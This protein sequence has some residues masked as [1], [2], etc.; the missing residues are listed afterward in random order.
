M[1]T[2]AT[3]KLLARI[4]AIGSG[5]TTIFV[6]SGSVTDPVNVTKLLSMGVVSSMAIGVLLAGRFSGFVRQSKVLWTLIGFFLLSGLASVLLSSSP[7][8]QG[9]YGS[10][11]GVITFDPGL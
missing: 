1:L 10:F 9:V 11:V 7:L 4:V 5:F 3:E 2:P 8:S 6:V